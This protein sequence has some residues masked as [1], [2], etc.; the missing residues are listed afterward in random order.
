MLAVVIIGTLAG[1]SVDVL[2]EVNVN[3]LAGLMIE[4]KFAMPVPLD[5]FSC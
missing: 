2:V 5:G 1:I 3:M 4:V